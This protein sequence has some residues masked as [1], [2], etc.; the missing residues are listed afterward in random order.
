[1]VTFLGILAFRKFCRESLE[2]PWLWGFG[3]MEAGGTGF[4]G[5]PPDCKTPGQE[6]HSSM[7]RRARM[8]SN[9]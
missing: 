3:F 5:K 1:M 9:C 6:S 8:K 7:L 2:E 4:H